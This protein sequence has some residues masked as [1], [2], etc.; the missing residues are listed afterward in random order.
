MKFN[1]WVGRLLP[2]IDNWPGSSFVE[3][4]SE[5]SAIVE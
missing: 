1:L 3:V 2:N 5:D 4:F